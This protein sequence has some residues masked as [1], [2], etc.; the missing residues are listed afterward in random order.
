MGGFLFFFPLPRS[1]RGPELFFSPPQ[2]RGRSEGLFSPFGELVIDLEHSS[3]SERILAPPLLLSLSCIER[4]VRF[5][6]FFL[7]WARSGDAASPFLLLRMKEEY[8]AIS[9]NDSYP[10]KTFG[11]SFFLRF[12]EGK[13]SS[14]FS[15]CALKGG[16]FRPT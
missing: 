9:R 12:W 15:I 8:E 4:G 2:G 14:F 16:F 7:L 10:P 1:D 6:S 5:L 11:L 3:V 13:R